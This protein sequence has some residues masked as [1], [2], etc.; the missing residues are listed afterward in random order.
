MAQTSS[1]L[2]SNRISFVSKRVITWVHCVLRL[3]LM[4]WCPLLI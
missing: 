3:N 2:L 4:I 1:I